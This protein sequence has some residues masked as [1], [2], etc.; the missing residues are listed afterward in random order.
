MD[1]MF[2][3]FGC[4]LFRYFQKH[5]FDK[6]IY[7]LGQDLKKF[8]GSLDSLHDYLQVD[9]KDLVPPSFSYSYDPSGEMI[10]NYYSS[11]RGL[12]GWVIG[13][14][15]TVAREIF[16]T[17][18]RMTL[19]GSE[20]DSI[21][22]AQNS[23]FRSLARIRVTFL[24]TASL[25]VNVGDYFQPSY[26]DCSLVSTEVFVH[27]FPYHVLFDQL[28]LVRQCG[29]AVQEF[30]PTLRSSDKLVKL[31]EAFD[32]VNPPIK[33]TPRHI[34]RFLNSSFTVLL[35]KRPD[36][37]EPENSLLLKVLSI[38]L[39]PRILTLGEMMEKRLCMSD[40]PIHDV[41]RELLQV[42]QQRVSEVQVSKRLDE[43]SGEMRRMAQALEEEKQRT[44]RLLTQLLPD[45]V[46]DQLLQGKKVAAEIFDD[47]T[48]LFS[49]IVSFTVL[50][51]QCSPM[52]VVELLNCL[53]SRFDAATEAN[54]VYKVE[55]IGDAYMV[56][57]GV[58]DPTPEHAS[59]VAEQAMDMIQAVGQVSSPV[60]QWKLQMPKELLFLCLFGG[61]LVAIA[62]GLCVAPFIDRLGSC[63]YI[64][65][66]P[67]VSSWCD[68]ARLCLG[69]GGE[70]LID[71]TAI[72]AV[73]HWLDYYYIGVTDLLVE[74]KWS[75]SGW[76]FANGS[77]F[78]VLNDTE[79]MNHSPNNNS[80]DDDF[81]VVSN[82]GLRDQPAN[83]AT[84]FVCQ[85]IATPNS[86]YLRRAEFLRLGNIS[87]VYCY[88]D[89]SVSSEFHCLWLCVQRWECRAVLFNRASSACRMLDF[90]DSSVG[91]AIETDPSWTKFI[92]VGLHTG[93]VVAGVVGDKMPRFCLF[94]AAVSVASQM[95]GQG[96]PGRIHVSPSS[97]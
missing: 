64:G 71:L 83:S 24:T 46:A 77:L 86:E 10:L 1:D 4:H 52:Q 82:A 69:I 56:A 55:T 88:T 38:H 84:K 37:R 26:P 60:P 85:P 49:D 43:I 80:P 36:S 39:L 65:D 90:A 25:A 95:E 7:T 45:K 19:L 93:P 78:P 62:T 16:G 33:F 75:R 74:A 61:G 15:T 40:L 27:C 63:L 28:M 53:F 3:M 5:G 29:I 94:G 59:R 81:L 50:A 73:N 13:M 41:T 91:D 76:R 51:G 92:R 87:P 18:I 11:R 9:N 14:L 35:R 97:R 31:T 68:A 70:L 79:W 66:N 44:R 2:E 12:N 20:S 17:E 21:E 8:I 30:C 23:R 48:I 42:N 6:M 34:K 96:V 32:L 47:C 58:P 57:A 54:S 72:R 22:L 67:S 89:A